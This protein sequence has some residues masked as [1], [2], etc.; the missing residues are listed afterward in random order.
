MGRTP[1]TRSVVSAVALTALLILL[2][3]C[4]G[5]GGSQEQ[6]PAPTNGLME[7]LAHV[8]AAGE[9]QEVC[10]ASPRRFLDHA[11]FQDV[12]TVEQAMALMKSQ[13]I[14]MRNVET[15]SPDLLDSLFSVG[16]VG[17][18][19]LY[20]DY[21]GLHFEK[22]RDLLGVEFFQVDDLLSTGSEYLDVVRGPFD[23]EAMSRTLEAQ[24]YSREDH[25]GTP[26]YAISGDFDVSFV[27][28]EQGYETLTELGAL[29]ID[30]MN[31]VWLRD[32]TL[33]AAPATQ[34]MTDAMD[35]ASGQIPSILDRPQYR[36]MA[37]GLGPV[38]AACLL[39]PAQYSDELLLRSTTSEEP[40]PELLERLPSQYPDW[41]SLNPPSLLALGYYRDPDGANVL[42]V[43]L[44]YDDKRKASANAP[45]LQ[46]RLAQYQSESWGKPL[47]DD[48]EAR[49]QAWS[50][51]SLVVGECRGGLA[52]QWTSILK[53]ADLLFLLERLPRQ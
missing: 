15:P 27:V 6:A 48:A 38:H 23:S 36:R 40:R 2:A 26:F 46:T 19:S 11:G 53:T 42:K 4:G 12:R 8:P 37:E 20:T 28:N 9:Y 45:E 14:A 44:Y 32:G 31:R 34:I 5:G 49:S 35:T 47:C 13:S 21:W 33:V 25:R 16:P 43:G 24:G 22:T 52:R 50:D 41:G 39:D 18:P 17:V 3:A 7:L 29:V 30:R 51:A 1:A 10:F